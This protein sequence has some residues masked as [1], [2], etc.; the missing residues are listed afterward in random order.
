LAGQL[1]DPP[2]YSQPRNEW[3]TT[4]MLQRVFGEGPR[5]ASQRGGTDL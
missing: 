4:R 5:S 3:K 2:R 1:A